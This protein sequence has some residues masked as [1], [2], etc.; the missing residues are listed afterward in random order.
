M[1]QQVGRSVPLSRRRSTRICVCAERLTEDGSPY[2]QFWFMATMP[3]QSGW[4][5][6]MHLRLE[7]EPVLP[8]S[9]QCSN[10][11]QKEMGA[12]HDPRSALSSPETGD[13]TLAGVASAVLS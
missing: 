11:F 5:L 10:A 13:A 3:A 8:T 9:L 4:W 12:L 6:S 7:W 1:N 2:L